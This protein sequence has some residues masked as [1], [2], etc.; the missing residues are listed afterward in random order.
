MN[1]PRHSTEEGYFD[2]RDS[3]CTIFVKVHQAMPHGYI[4]SSMA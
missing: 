3:G 1:A 4:L 2:L